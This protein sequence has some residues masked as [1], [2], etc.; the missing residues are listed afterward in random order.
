MSFNPGLE[1]SAKTPACKHGPR[2]R[3]AGCSAKSGRYWAAA[4]CPDSS[5]DPAWFDAES[6]IG[7]ALEAWWLAEGAPAEPAELAAVAT[8][9]ADDVP[10]F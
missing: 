6:I 5:C 8:A 10:P 2:V 3:R 9:T 1:P 7:E 4:F